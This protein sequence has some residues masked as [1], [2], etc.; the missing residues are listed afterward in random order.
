MQF[1]YESGLFAKG[2]PILDLGGADLQGAHLSGANT[3]GPS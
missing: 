1:L 2:R 3:R